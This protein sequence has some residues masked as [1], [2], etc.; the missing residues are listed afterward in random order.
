MAKAVGHNVPRAEG[1]EKVTGEAR[2]VDDLVLANM[3]W[4][5]TVRSTIPRG[6]IL[7]VELDQGFDWSGFTVVDHRDIPGKN[8]VAMI[9]DDQ[10]NLAVDQTRHQAE[11]VVLLAHADRER[12]DEAVAHVKIHCAPEPPIL[13]LD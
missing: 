7:S 5:R 9:T 3:I 11:P 12:L 13:D 1:R 4:G 8:V 6:R 2:Y 10:P